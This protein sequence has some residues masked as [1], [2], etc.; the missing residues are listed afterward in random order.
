MPKDGG[1][2]ASSKRREDVRFLTGVGNYTDDINIHGQ[3]YVYFFTRNPPAFRL[4]VPAQPDLNNDGGQR[5]FGA[6]H[7][8]ELAYVFDNLDVVGIGWDEQDKALAETVADYWF[9]FAA[10]GNPNGPGLPQ[11]R[12][13]NPANDM[14]QILDTPVV[15]DIH[16]RRQFMNLMEAASAP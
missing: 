4:Y 1:I 2:G 13:F 6:Y 10:T 12:V 9:N 5:A 7:S 14:V 11:W 15:N 8:G 3:A 16:P